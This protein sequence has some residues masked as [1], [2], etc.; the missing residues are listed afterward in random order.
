MAAAPG[1]LVFVFCAVAMAAAVANAADGEEAASVVVGLA[2]CA[3]CTRK[4][5]NAEEVF[6][7]LQVVIK[8]NNSAGDYEQ[9]AAGAL[10]SSGAFSIPLAAATDEI[11]GGGC[12]AQLQSAEGT[13]CSGQEPSWIH[14]FSKGT[15]IAI[16]GKTHDASSQC[17]AAICTWI[18][19]HF[20]NHYNRKRQFFDH[21]FGPSPAPAN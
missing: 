21:F 9:K 19:Q 20:F 4:N 6:K 11:D 13:P 5:M 16:A 15:W 8:C 14:P 3:D 12:F 18:K 1:G 10:D 17:G 2:K 7:A